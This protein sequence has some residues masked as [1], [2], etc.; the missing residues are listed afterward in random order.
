MNNKS[1]IELKDE[2]VNFFSLTTTL[3]LSKTTITYSNLE[4]MDSMWR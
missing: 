1:R 2:K 4:R 3:F